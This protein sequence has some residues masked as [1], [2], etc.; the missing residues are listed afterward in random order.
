[1]V[2]SKIDLIEDLDSN[3]IIAENLNSISEH[4]NE[5]NIITATVNAAKAFRT[6]KIAER[7]G[8]RRSCIFQLFI[9]EF[10]LIKLLCKHKSIVLV[11]Y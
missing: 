10:K 11:R 7:I 4:G 2:I 3:E 9:D 5:K 8:L 1:M 6:I